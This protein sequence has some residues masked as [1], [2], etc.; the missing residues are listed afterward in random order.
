M[1]DL[2]KTFQK[3]GRKR[4]EGGRAGRRS[5]ISQDKVRDYYA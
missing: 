3:D 5:V 2:G 1:Q 4:A